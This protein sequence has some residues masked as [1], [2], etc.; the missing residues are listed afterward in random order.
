MKV[1]SINVG[2]PREHYWRDEIV[3]TSLQSAVQKAGEATIELLPPAVYYT[4]H[5]WGLADTV[6]GGVAFVPPGLVFLL[7]AWRFVRF[8]FASQVA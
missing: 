4:N 5:R 1:V 2:Q 8:A 6:A 7:F 3:R